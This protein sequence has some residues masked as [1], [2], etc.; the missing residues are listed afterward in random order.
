MAVTCNCMLVSM[1]CVFSG[2]LFFASILHLPDGACSSALVASTQMLLL[3]LGNVLMREYNDL[4]AGK[5]PV[6]P[7]NQC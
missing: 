1:R 7:V 3:L 6:F 5:A 4:I 2:S